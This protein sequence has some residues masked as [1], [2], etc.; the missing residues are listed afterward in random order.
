MSIGGGVGILTAA[1]EGRPGWRVR[2]IATLLLP[3]R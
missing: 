3:R 1:P 2:F